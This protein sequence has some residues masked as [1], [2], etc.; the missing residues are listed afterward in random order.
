MVNFKFNQ[1][2]TIPSF[3]DVNGEEDTATKG[4]QL[5]AL[6]EIDVSRDIM[7]FTFILNSNENINEL[8]YYVSIEEWTPLNFKVLVN[9]TTPTMISKG[10]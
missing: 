1:N 4:R 8:K 3:I 9:F 6:K 10:L 2:V 7:D 5:L